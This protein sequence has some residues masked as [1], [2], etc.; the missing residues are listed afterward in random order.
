MDNIELNS[1][2][3]ILREVCRIRNRWVAIETL[4]QTTKKGKPAKNP[5]TL[6]SSDLLRKMRF[7][8]ARYR[9]QRALNQNK[10]ATSNQEEEI[11]NFKLPSFEE[12]FINGFNAVITE[13]IYE[14]QTASMSI[15]LEDFLEQTNDNIIEKK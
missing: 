5:C 2:S 9:K 8:H 6:N 3:I 15:T 10:T 14:I 11:E 1:K 12:T 4:K 7:Y 13:E